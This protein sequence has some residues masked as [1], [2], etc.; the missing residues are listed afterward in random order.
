MALAWLLDLSPVVVPI[1]G[2]RLPETAR[3]AARAAALSLD[4]DATSLLTRAFGRPLVER[5]R[6]RTVS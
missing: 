5:P 6:L 3:S 4:A 1:P 2:A